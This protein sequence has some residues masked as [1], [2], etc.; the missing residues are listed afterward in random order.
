LGSSA[1]PD[2][3]PG[4]FTE[5]CRQS[6]SGTIPPDRFTAPGI[7]MDVDASGFTI[8]DTTPPPGGGFYRFEA[9][10]GP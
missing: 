1:I 8:T 10:S 4:S 7:I 9:R 3:S 5:I 2:L 6:N